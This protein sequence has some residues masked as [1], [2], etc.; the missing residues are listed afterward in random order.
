MIER[1][2]KEIADMTNGTL[3]DTAYYQKKITGVTTDTRK[4][5]K[6]QLFVPIS[7]ENFNGHT[8]AKAA[9]EKGAAAVLWSAAEPDPPEHG[10]VIVVNDTLEALQQLASAYRK[11]INPKVVG[12]TGSNGKTT[13]KD[14]IYSILT[15]EY[16]VHKT[17]G[18]YNNHIGLPLTILDMPEETE[19]AILE[20]GMSAKGE[21]DFLTKLAKP[22]IA[23]IT[24]IGDSHLLDLGSREN[25]ADAKFEI[26]NGLS[27][28]G[29][30]IYTG[31]EPL[32]ADKVKNVA[33][34]LKSFGENKDN[35]YQIS[36]IELGKEGTYF[37]LRDIEQPF[38]IP[39]LGKHN[40]RNAL[41]AI[42]AANEFHVDLSR[43]A[44]G[45]T[46][47]KMTGMRL[48]MLQM[49]DGLSIINDAY[50]ASPTSMRAAI[51]LLQGMQGFRKKHL[52]LGDILELGKDEKMYH[53]QIGMEIDSSQIQFV[54]TYGKLGEY[55][56]NGANGNFQ[57][58]CVMHFDDK[59]AL[60][61]ELQN[62]TAPED[63]VLIKASR[64]MKLEDV[65][66]HL[67]IS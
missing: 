36:E 13:T 7:G 50:N 43:I 23:V 3:G 35:S 45:L 58:G 19:I 38:Y 51:D 40:V 20:M 17:Q 22:D 25:I 55:I 42:A 49:S 31:D 67:K 62:R 26:A 16:R 24:N 53:E 52:V 14:M 44:E 41:A 29:V 37:K 1:T 48:E 56:A 5:E 10:A 54:Y 57:E 65:I 27:K 66:S 2:A 8:F 6:G 28:D 61:R 9:L 64:G 11:S 63:I 59:K 30:L 12:V 39:V 60:A 18:N 34:A 47:L 15:T 33:F 32:L 4:I 21:I 46:N